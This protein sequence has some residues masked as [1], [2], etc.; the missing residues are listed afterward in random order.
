MLAV[1]F[2]N[3]ILNAGLIFFLNGSAVWPFL[4]LWAFRNPFTFFKPVARARPQFPGIYLLSM[5]AFFFLLGL[6]RVPAQLTSPND[7]NPE[8]SHRHN[9][10]PEGKVLN[11]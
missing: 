8:I 7:Q 3:G 1:S 9:S 6:V 4:T 5:D 10:R 11:S 2:E